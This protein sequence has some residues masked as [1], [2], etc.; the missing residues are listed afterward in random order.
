MYAVK[1]GATR[2]QR[3]FIA[4]SQTVA[5]TALSHVVYFIVIFIKVL[6]NWQNF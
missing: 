6:P 2:P 1:L 4:V 3:R 5:A